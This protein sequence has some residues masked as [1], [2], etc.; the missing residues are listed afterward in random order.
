MD[1]LSFI[2]PLINIY[3]IRNSLSKYL[4]ISHVEFDPFKC[5]YCNSEMI[6]ASKANCDH[7]FC[8]YCISSNLKADKNYLCPICKTV[9][10][11][12]QVKPIIIIEEPLQI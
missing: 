9:L 11:L 1:L 4:P 6:L 12:E 8:Y 7:N 10:K 3:K 2:I 5:G